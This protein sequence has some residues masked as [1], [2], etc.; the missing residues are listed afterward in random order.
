M[1]TDPIFLICDCEKMGS[2]R[3]CP[4]F[5]C[6]KFFEVLACFSDRLFI[7]LYTAR[8]GSFLSSSS[9]SFA[10]ITWS[11]ILRK[12]A[13][14]C[15]GSLIGSEA[16]STRGFL[17]LGAR[18]AQPSPPSFSTPWVEGSTRLLRS[19]GSCRCEFGVLAT[20]EADH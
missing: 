16:P 2:V 12:R 19:A 10:S 20:T 6:Q 15:G 13:S 9:F 8:A 5:Y 11:P 17:P 7:C 4:H 3:V 14:S 18:A 1:G